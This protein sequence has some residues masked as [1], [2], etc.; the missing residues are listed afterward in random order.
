M[1]NLLRM[2]RIKWNCQN[3]STG[4][5]EKSRK[6]ESTCQLKKLQFYSPREQCNYRVGCVGFIATFTI[7]LNTSWSSQQ[8]FF[9]VGNSR[10][11][12]R[13]HCRHLTPVNGFGEL[14]ISSADDDASPVGIKSHSELRI[15]AR[16]YPFPTRCLPSNPGPQRLEMFATR[17]AKTRSAKYRRKPLVETSVKCRSPARQPVNAGPAGWRH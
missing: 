12:C 14:S 3:G 9:S 5:A 4:C 8:S 6:E 17:R 16:R 11:S 10:N 7:L 15:G 2:S 1:K 13:I